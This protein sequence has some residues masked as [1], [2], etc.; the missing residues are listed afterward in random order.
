MSSF[1]PKQSS[2]V[3]CRTV[4]KSFKLCGAPFFMGFVLSRLYPIHEARATACSVVVPQPVRLWQADTLL[5]IV[6]TRAA[7]YCVVR[8][9]AE[10]KKK[11][12]CAYRTRWGRERIGGGGMRGASLDFQI[13]SRVEYRTESWFRFSDSCCLLALPLRIFF[14]HPSW[15]TCSFS[16]SLPEIY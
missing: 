4:S 16:F 14:W 8:E 2:T 15:G 10:W 3:D 13:I 11:G 6:Q 9:T 7:I 5:W 12:A 1:R